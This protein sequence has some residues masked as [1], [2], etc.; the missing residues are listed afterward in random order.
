[1]KKL[2]SSLVLF[3][4]FCSIA[5]NQIF[6]RANVTGNMETTIQYLNDDSTIGAFAP[7]QKA[8][9][10]SYL[11]VNYSLGKFRTGVRFESYLPS[12]AGYPAFYSG[13][14]IGYRFAEYSG[15]KIQVTMG[16]FFEQFG[17][18]LIFRSYEERALGLDNA[19]D[20]ARIRFSPIK[21]M[22]LKGVYGRQRFNFDDG[23]VILS[24]GVVRGF[25]G[26]VN[27]NDLIPSFSDSKLKVSLGGSFVS[28]YESANNDTLIIPKNVG[29]YGGRLSL[30]Y[31][32]FYINGEYIHKEN[33]P[34]AQ[35]NYIYNSGHGILINMGYSKKGLG[36][37]LSA[38][39]IDNLSYRSQRDVIG[40]QLFI[41]YLPALSN[42]HTYNLAGTLY[43]YAS[44][45][46]GEVAYQLDFLYKIP[47]K[48]KIGGKYGTDLH[49]NVSVV[50][51]PVQH[52]SNM[53]FNVDRIAY[54]GRPFDGSDSLYNFDLNFHVSRKFNKK[55]KASAHYFH[56]VFNNEVNTVTKKASGYITSDIGVIDMQ[57]KI[58]RKHALRMEIQGLF[59]KQDRGNWA[60]ALL[61]Y[62]ISPGWFVAVMDQWNYGNSTVKDRLHYL[63]GSF[64]YTHNSSRFMFTFGKQRE[65][66]FCIGGVCRPVPA[67]NGLT[68][69]FTTTF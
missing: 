6:D 27:L 13:T 59:T 54:E 25:D 24:E 29:S 33:D 20:G 18:G 37:L 57:Y 9:M 53:N 67:T 23:K 60:T 5:Q 64:G 41:N 66:I 34:S 17:S 28:K 19:M 3:L 44:Q 65:G 39:S 35:N 1:M 8:V 16:N 22:Q 30:R 46:N 48:T 51:A 43:P 14:G 12:I 63:L 36:I 31:S 62:T 2:L 32:K 10:N 49:L 7:E 4:P 42:Q 15:E 40:N 38:K 47:K 68:F 69:T 55:F 56:F 11:N 50:T 58:N 26:D 21:G 52:T 45:P 61:E